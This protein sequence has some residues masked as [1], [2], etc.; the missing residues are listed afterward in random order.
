MIRILNLILETYFCRFSYHIPYLFLDNR[1][2][3]DM[4]S[5]IN[6]Y[7][8]FLKLSNMF[9]SKLVCKIKCFFQLL[10]FFSFCFFYFACFFFFLSLFTHSNYIAAHRDM[11]GMIR[12]SSLD[13]P[14]LL[15]MPSYWHSHSSMLGLLFTLQAQFEM[16][17][18]QSE[19][20]EK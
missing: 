19:K 2:K 9:Q 14:P 5:E 11:L 18:G 6:G 7:T 17:F 12:R 16:R 3:M 15:P 13:I 4:N 1:Q 8:P 10:F 20:E